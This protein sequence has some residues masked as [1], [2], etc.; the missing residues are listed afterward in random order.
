LIAKPKFE[1]LTV[2]LSNIVR[3]SGQE[4]GGEL[5]EPTTGVWGGA[6]GKES[7]AKCPEAERFFAFAQP[8]KFANLS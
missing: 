6:P 1:N 8:E 3:H 5:C 4:S 7:G 2:A